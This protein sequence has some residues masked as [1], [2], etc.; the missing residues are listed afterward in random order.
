MITPHMFSHVGTRTP[1]NIPSFF[2]DFFFAPLGRDS[3]RIV[4]RADFEGWISG[5]LRQMEDALDEA[6]ARAGI[7]ATEIDKVFLTGGSSFVPA[8]RTIFENRF[9]RSRIETGGE[10]LSI[11]HGLALVGTEE[12]FP[13]AA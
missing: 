10:L 4:R 11:A 6:I 13:W 9:D 5:E 2:S 1:L 12:N 7:A 8:V 3:R